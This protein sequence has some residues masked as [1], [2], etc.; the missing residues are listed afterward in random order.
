MPFRRFFPCCCELYTGVNSVLSYSIKVSGTYFSARSLADDVG[1]QI[2][3]TTI[4]HKRRLVRRLDAHPTQSR[5][6]VHVL[7]NGWSK[8]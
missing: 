6:D 4:H 7:V 8:L 3:T 1:L 2:R 5:L